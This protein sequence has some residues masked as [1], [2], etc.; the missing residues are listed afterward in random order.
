MLHDFLERERNS[1]IQTAKQKAQKLRWG[2]LAI[3]AIEDSWDVFY[4]DLAG[5]VRSGTLDGEGNLATDGR[6]Q[7]YL[8]LG[9]AI[10]DAVQSYNIIH[11]SITEAAASHGLKISEEEL[12]RLNSSL[13]I[14]IAQVV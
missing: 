3:T 9:F 4:D 10:T 7:E 14:A 6:G 13:D 12:H 1:I 11:Q 5:L 2:R 8:K